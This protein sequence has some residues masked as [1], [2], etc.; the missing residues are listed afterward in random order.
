MLSEWWSD[1]KYRLR[2][3]FRRADMER[4]LDD[5]LRFHVDRETEKLVRAGLSLGE[6]RRQARLAFGGM[7]RT[8]EESRDARGVSAL[9]IV[10][11]DLRYAM[12]GLRASPGFAAAVIVT[13]ALGIGANAAMFGII[14]R[15]M[16]RPPAYLHAPELV[17]R[18]YLSRIVRGSE[19]TDSRTEYTRYLDFRKYTS[20][21][22][23]IVAFG[24]RPIAVGLGDEAR[25]VP[26]GTVSAGFWSLFEARPALGRFFAPDED[27]P[28]AGSPVAVISDAYW[29]TRFAGARD[30]I[31]KSLWVGTLRYTIIGVAPVGFSGIDPD[32]PAAIWIPITSFAGS[33]GLRD[34]YYRNYDWS[35]LQML[36]RR[37]AGITEAAATA[38][39]T[40]AYLRSWNA[41]R[42]LDGVLAAPEAARPRAA[43]GSLFESRG[44]SASAVGKVAVWLGG[45]TA[46]V[47]L[48]AC[49]NVANLMLARALRRRRE[50]ALRLALGV[51]RG[52]L[53]SQLLTEGLLLALFGG[54]AGL[55]VAQLGGSLVRARFLPDSPTTNV[56]YDGRT[57]LFAAATA[58][59][60]GLVTG[61][62]PMLRASRGDL[63][64]SLKAGSREGT[65]QRSRART[66]LLLFQGALSVVLLVGAGLFVRSLQNVR[67]LRLG[68]DPDPVMI[69]DVELRGTKLERQQT[70]ALTRSM[71]E[72]AKAMP[73]VE[74][75]AYGVSIPFWST[76]AISISV[77]GIDSVRKLGQFTL[78]A[79]T[80]EYFATMGTRI[81]RGRAF[82]PE[83]DHANVPRV[84]VVSESMARK[85]WPGE[86]ALGKCVH[87]RADTIPCATVIGI[88][89]DIKQ[90]SLT[91]AEGL[92][93][94]VPITQFATDDRTLFIRTR[95]AAARQ[96][97][98]VRRA[99]QTLL[100]GAAYVTLT[101]MREIVGGPMQS[102]EVGA[103]MF[104]AFGVLAL[105][106]A[107]VGLYSVVA[108]TVAQR[109][110]ELGVRIALGARSADVVRLVV[111]QGVRFAAAGIAIGGAIAYW[112]GRFIGP[113]LFD[114]SPRDPVVYGVVAVVLLA[115]AV[116][117]TVVPARRATRVDPVLAM[118]GD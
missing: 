2:A 96:V 118:R 55:V 29:R 42:A 30:I 113:L 3:L 26:V 49:A 32:R 65:Y 78:Q 13:L 60:V 41:E 70:E 109:T 106:V 27:V 47:L 24:Q 22:D 23:Q 45:V 6:A 85:L 97:E 54:V 98:P 11:Q 46:I 62:A 35:W 94:Y 73:A 114:V 9:D 117:A 52:R 59:F 15:L 103:T 39:L 112:A 64:D 91:R 57:L 107:G 12:R 110:Q 37:K 84:I 16:F 102:W 74:H 21:F 82:G 104:L 33:G 18:V 31:G 25:E 40:N 67:A 100:P 8:K 28:P 43:A 72:A 89:E 38:D 87:V 111:G 5:E 56:L 116:V 50:I 51:S 81:I 69:A 4:D 93:Y 86:D 66:A 105:L 71:L 44:P 10:G 63:T 58:V 115:V 14:D 48:I 101:P 108:Y 77:P 80:P 20:A 76:Y 83:D 92:N 34:S 7:D 53:L 95:G 99:L 75:A 61:L 79:A 88:A 19:R 1:V 17:H 90:N 36:A 68:Y